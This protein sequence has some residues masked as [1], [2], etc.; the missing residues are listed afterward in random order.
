MK[1]SS[2]DPI[3]FLQSFPFPVL[4]CTL[5][6]P[7]QCGAPGRAVCSLLS[8]GLC[9]RPQLAGLTERR[10][11]RSL[12]QARVNKQL[13]FEDSAD[14]LRGSYQAQAAKHP[15]ATF[16]ESPQSQHLIRTISL[17]GSGPAAPRLPAGSYLSGAVRVLGAA[18]WRLPARGSH[19][20]SAEALA[21]P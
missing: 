7:R 3:P 16:L 4:K 9:D 18:A 5:S 2:E 11:R 13:S 14:T 6:G 10:R 12:T 17:P 15:A 19:A 21:S 1:R 20:G 8:P